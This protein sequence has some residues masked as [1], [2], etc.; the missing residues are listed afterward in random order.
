MPILCNDELSAHSRP[1]SVTNLASHTP[2]IAV[3]GVDLGGGGVTATQSDVLLAS[4]RTLESGTANATN[5]AVAYQR[6]GVKSAT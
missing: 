4:Y 3:E 1:H 2:I 6:V 5:L